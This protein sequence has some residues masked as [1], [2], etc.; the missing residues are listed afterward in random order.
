MSAQPADDLDSYDLSL[1][2]LMHL[3]RRRSLTVADLEGLD[4]GWAGSS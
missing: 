2:A 4:R 1:A 3:A